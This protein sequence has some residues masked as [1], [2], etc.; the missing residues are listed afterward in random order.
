MT[1]HFRKPLL[2]AQSLHK[3]FPVGKAPGLFARAR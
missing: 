1:D 2:D 3:Q